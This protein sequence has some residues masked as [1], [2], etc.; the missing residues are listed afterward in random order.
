[1]KNNLEDKEILSPEL[2]QVIDVILAKSPR[3]VFGGSIVLNALGFIER[4]IKD[5]DLFIHDYE[6]TVDY[7]L[8]D[9]ISPLEN[10]GASVSETTTDINGQEIRRIGIK[11][12]NTNC[13]IFSVPVLNSSEFK[14]SGRTI[15][16]QNVN[17]AI[18][19]KKAYVENTKNKNGYPGKSYQ[20][21]QHDLDSINNYLDSLPF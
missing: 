19:A 3:I 2:L 5:I 4:P 17:E 13:C 16:I 7:K 18:L 21:H 11:I 20:K 14:F 15:R 8:T 1:M 6:S 9:L 12:N 10:G